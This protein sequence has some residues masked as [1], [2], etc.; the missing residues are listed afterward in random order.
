LRWRFAA[1]IWASINFYLS[2]MTG[3]ILGISLRIWMAIFFN[4][5]FLQ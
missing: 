5:F 2:M 1:V 4:C 3:S